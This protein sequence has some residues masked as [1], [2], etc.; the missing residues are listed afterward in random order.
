MLL[1][2]LAGAS[3]G[4]SGDRSQL[5]QFLLHNAG[6][7]PIGRTETRHSQNNCDPN[8]GPLDRW[9]PPNRWVKPTRAGR[10]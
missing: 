9:K 6:A 2:L 5:T 3:S 10:W 4:A 1:L 7:G 8:G